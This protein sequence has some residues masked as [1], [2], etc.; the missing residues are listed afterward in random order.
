MLRKLNKAHRILSI[1][2][3]MAFSNVQGEPGF[4]EMVIDYFDRA[5]K[6]TNIPNDMLKIIKYPDST[7]KLNIPFVKDDGTYDFVEAYRCHHKRH[8]LPCKGGT[9]ISPHVDLD[10]VEAL[11]TLMSFKLATV[12]VPFGGSKGGLKMDPRNYSKSETERIMRR[13]TIE[14]AKYNYIG[15]AVDV[16]GPDV[17]TNTWH[18]DIMADTYKTLYG[19][20]DIDHMGVVT[21]KSIVSG[22]INGRNE[23]TGLGVYYCIRNVFEKEEHEPIRQ[24]YDISQGLENKTA[25]VQG[26]GAVGYWASHFLVKDGVKIIGVQEYNGCVYNENGIDIDALK[27]HLAQ[28][29]GVIGH[30]DMIDNKTVIEREC[31]ILIPAALE[32]ALNKHNCEQIKAKVIAEGGNGVSTV[33]ADKVFEQKGILVIPDILCNAAGVTCSYLEWL[34][35]L[36]HKQPGR[37]V[38]KWEEKSKQ[39]MVV[40]LEKQFREQGY[41]IDLS[42]LPKEVIKGP[43]DLDLVYTGLEKIMNV[44]MRQAIATSVKKDCSLRMGVFVNAIERIYKCYENS[45]LSLK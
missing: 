23:S 11:A 15:S 2:P 32:K 17:G 16:P 45:G 10:E 35:N 28:G 41:N 39:S 33:N 42:N 14:M 3:Q 7:L 44:A 40:E 21:G 13:Y 22:G 5:S 36:E 26:F 31:D 20:H 18:M 27:E 1:R 19:F 43:S 37:L 24:N 30:P 6:Y 38:T 12:E 25:I 34:K 29:N 9:R 8:R 4:S